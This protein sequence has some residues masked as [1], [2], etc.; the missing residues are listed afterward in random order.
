MLVILQ[1]ITL[2]QNSGTSGVQCHPALSAFE[3]FETNQLEDVTFI[4][5][6]SA[7][8]NLT[9]QG[10]QLAGGGGSSSFRPFF[11]NWK[12]WYLV[13]RASS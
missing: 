4:K 5:N 8:K 10:A 2:P 9:D 7:S 3:W 12:K 6:L 1:A 11:E 13:S